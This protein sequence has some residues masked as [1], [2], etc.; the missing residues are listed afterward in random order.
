MFELIS[1]QIEKKP[2]QMMLNTKIRVPL[3]TIAHESCYTCLKI[4]L[5]AHVEVIR[6]IQDE[7]HPFI[8]I[9]CKFQLNTSVPH[10]PIEHMIMENIYG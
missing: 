8:D 3:V 5:G 9:F 6:T 4:H 7:P 10:H 1:N 2:C